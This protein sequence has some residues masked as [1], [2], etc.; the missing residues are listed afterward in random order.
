[1]LKR[2]KRRLARGA[3]YR[4]SLL[5]FYQYYF[6]FSHYTA[7]MPFP[8]LL[9]W[10]ITGLHPE[11]RWNAFTSGISA[12]LYYTAS[13]GFAQPL[14]PSFQLFRHRPC[15]RLR[16]KRRDGVADDPELALHGA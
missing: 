5:K 16:Q 9:D 15:E 3:H 14:D 12:C 6:L 7:L 2:E 11:Y 1:M 8:Q 13:G 4:F 10:N